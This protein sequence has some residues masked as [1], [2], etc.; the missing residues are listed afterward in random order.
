[1]MAALGP[2]V[3]KKDIERGKTSALGQYG[4]KIISVGLDE[5]EI[6]KPGA[7]ALSLGARDPLRDD[8]D[9]DAGGLAVERRIGGQEVA[10]PAA[11]FP[12]EGGARLQDF[13]AG[14]PQVGA[15]LDKDCGV[16]RAQGRIDSSRHFPAPA[17][18]LT[19]RRLISDGLTPL[20]R[21]ACPRV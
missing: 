3:G 2:R 11:D 5:V 1:V 18:I 21:L 4:E 19:I 15:A 7:V 13:R 16:F 10:V 20:I 9:P 8:V 17:A 6:G 12:D 14:L